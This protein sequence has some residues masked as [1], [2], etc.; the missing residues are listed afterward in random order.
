MTFCSAE[1]SVCLSDLASTRA[2]YEKKLRRLLQAGAGDEQAD[3]EQDNAGL[4]SDSG[5]EEGETKSCWFLVDTTP[6]ESSLTCAESEGG[7]EETVEQS[8]Q[9][10]SVSATR[11]PPVVIRERTC[12]PHISFTQ[13][14]TLNTN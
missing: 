6:V 9:E 4:Y 7:E 2:V 10:V 8:Q 1:I 13:F 12:T 3:G 11:Y 5:D 14:G